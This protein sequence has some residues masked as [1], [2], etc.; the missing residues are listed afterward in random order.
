MTEVDLQPN[1]NQNSSVLKANMPKIYTNLNDHFA[2]KRF[3]KKAKM[4]ERPQMLTIKCITFPKMEKL[5][6]RIQS[7]NEFSTL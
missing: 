1:K 2:M 7:T 5:H 4:K 3:N 6:H